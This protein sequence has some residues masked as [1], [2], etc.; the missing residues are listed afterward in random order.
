MKFVRT[1]QRARLHDIL[2][3]DAGGKDRRPQRPAGTLPR[4]SRF[5]ALQP[6]ARSAA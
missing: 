1:A 6:L 5:L 4:A 2:A 3:Q